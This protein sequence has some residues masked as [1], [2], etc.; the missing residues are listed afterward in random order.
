MELAKSKR[1]TEVQRIAIHRCR[2]VMCYCLDDIDNS[3]LDSI[4]PAP[5]F[6]NHPQS[7]NSSRRIKSYSLQDKSRVSG[8][9]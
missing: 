5:V 8:C 6:R 4:P 2:D 3:R 7:P 1:D 9:L